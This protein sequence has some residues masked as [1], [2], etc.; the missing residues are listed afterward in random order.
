[1]TD[2]DFRNQVIY[3]IQDTYIKELKNKYSMF[4]GIMCCYIL[5]D[6]INY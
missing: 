2:K 4:L 6:L 3:I 5:K 1:M